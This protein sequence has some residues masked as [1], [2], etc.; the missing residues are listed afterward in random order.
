MIKLS[1]K[2]YIYKVLINLY[3]YEVSR[4]SDWLLA[5]RQRGQSSSPGGLK[6]FHFSVS[7]CPALGSTKP[8]TQWVHG[9]LSPGVNRSERRADHSPPVNAEAKKIWIYASTPPYAF[10]V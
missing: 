4:D 5:G 2:L 3:S 8:P 7:S 9:A 10:M 1:D 6:N